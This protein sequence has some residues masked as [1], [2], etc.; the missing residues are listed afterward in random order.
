MYQSRYRTKGIR[1]ELTDPKLP[2]LEETPIIPRNPFGITIREMSDFQLN[3]GDVIV[4][5]FEIYTFDRYG[6]Q[7]GEMNPMDILI[8]ERV[9]EGVE[10]ER[11]T[12]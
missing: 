5:I 8:D 11:R 3:L 12:L 10:R 2:A 1:K 7:S 4:R 9:R 6:S